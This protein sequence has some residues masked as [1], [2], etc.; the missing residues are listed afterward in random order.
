MTE[1]K[2]LD[3]M[4]KEAIA[5]ALKQTSTAVEAAKSL[6]VSRATLYRLMK[7][8]GLKRGEAVCQSQ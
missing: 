3:I 7:K 2:T 4:E 1:L 5:A 8:H 6:G